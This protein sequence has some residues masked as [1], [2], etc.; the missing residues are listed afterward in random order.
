MDENKNLNKYLLFVTI[1]SYSMQIIDSKNK[2]MPYAQAVYGEEEKKAIRDVYENPKKIVAGPAVKEFEAKIA[3]LF[4]KTHGVMVN[5]GSSANLIALEMLGLSQ[6][7]EVITPVLTFSTTLAPILQKGLTPVFVD[8]VPG[9]YLIDIDQIEAKITSK[10]RA[11]MIPSLLGNIPDMKRLREIVDKHSL[12]LIEDSCDTIGSTF[13]G[14][15]TGVCSDISTTSFY[16][17]H[18]ITAAGAGGMACFK[19]EALARRARVM[20]YWGR[21]STLFGHYEQS[22][23]IAKR[24]AGRLDGDVYDAKFIFSEIGYNM[25]PTEAQGA[26]GLVQLARLN[27]FA[28]IR[29]KHFS[30][31]LSF[32]KQY[33]HFFVLP[34][35]NIRVQANN[36][37]FPL[38]IKES[39]PFTRAEMTKYLEERNI[40][41]RPIFTGNV[42][43]QPAFRSSLQGLSAR[44]AFP[45]ADYVMKHGFVVGCHHGLHDEQITYF[46][47]TVR[48][49]ISSR[50]PVVSLSNSHSDVMGPS[51]KKESTPLAP[52]A[53]SPSGSFSPLVWGE[54]ATKNILVTGGYGF[55]GSNF[56]R[57]LYH[58]YPEYRIFNLDLLT[59]CGNQENLVDI[60]RFEASVDSSNKRYHF[61]Y[62]DVCDERL[63]NV[64][65]Q[66][67]QFDVVVNFAAETHVDRS[68]IDMQDFIRTNIGGARSLAEAVRR[69]GSSRFIHISTDE[70]YGDVEGGTVTETS[71]LCPSNPYSSSKAAADLIVQSFIRTHKVPAIIVR[72]SNN[73]GPYQYPEKLIP[74]AI[75]NI[76]EGRKIPIHGSGEQVRTWVHV[77]DF[78]NAVDI[79]MHH[80]PVHTI[81]N[82]AHEPKKNVEVLDMIAGHLRVNLDAVAEHI[83][84]RPGGDQ[85]YAPDAAKI[86]TELNWRPM[87]SM[88]QSLGDIVRWYLNN[89]EW[90]G[91]IKSSDEYQ[92][93][94]IRQSR[95]QWY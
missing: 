3:A 89:R 22:E 61:I 67:H 7:A 33:E 40:Q 60:E 34:V 6:G 5:S 85:R 63:L 16:A 90:W 87:H 92:V 94:Y 23:D 59:Y 45:V 1:C 44:A 13:D 82:V 66:R 58:K 54:H 24:F 43:R 36:L 80:A 35:Q 56:I 15:P 12:S 81:Y 20:A 46:M 57:H 91:K 19:D 38:T 31:L 30:A 25:Q 18:I 28:A 41:T 75:T 95:G 4:G 76:I 11:L 10:T 39:A 65:F 26:F 8:V 93:H 71:P 74:L 9:T 42:L 49:Y 51:E 29:K 70:I 50:T 48:E 27:E 62:G 2:H 32:F 78:C 17:S 69:F 21:E 88:E 53:P 14:Q 64:I 52:T 72:G 47:E 55:M 73:Y 86:K 37:C 84:D 79:V 77:Q 83:S 68:I